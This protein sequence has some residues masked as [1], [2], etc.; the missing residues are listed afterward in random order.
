MK[1]SEMNMER[2]HTNITKQKLERAV[3]PNTAS[4]E[5]VWHE[6]RAPVATLKTKNPSEQVSGCKALNYEAC[7]SGTKHRSFHRQRENHINVYYCLYCGSCA[8]VDFGS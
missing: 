5:K 3:L 7:G 8:A 6:K 1:N 2:K 4:V